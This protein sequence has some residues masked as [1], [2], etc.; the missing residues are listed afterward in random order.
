M[1]IYSQNIL[2]EIAALYKIGKYSLV[3]FGNKISGKAEDKYNFQRG[4]DTLQCKHDSFISK[5]FDHLLTV[6]KK[7]T[8]HSN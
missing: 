2:Q 5:L 8:S 4:Y 6:N 7:V 3:K 1:R